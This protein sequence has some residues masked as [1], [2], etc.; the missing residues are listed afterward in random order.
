MNSWMGKFL[1]LIIGSLFALQAM[2]GDKPLFTEN[3]G[4]T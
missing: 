2:A 1:L 4:G 3:G